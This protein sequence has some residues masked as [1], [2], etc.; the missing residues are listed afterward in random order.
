MNYLHIHGPTY[1]YRGEQLDAPTLLFVVDHHCSQWASEFEVKKLLANSKCNSK[2]HV[3]V[4]DHVVAQ[5]EFLENSCICMPYLLVKEEQ[6]FN[7]WKPTVNL[8]A[9]TS[10]FNFMINKARP[11]RD[12]LLML[13]EYF[14]LTD[15]KYTLCW[16]TAIINRSAHQAKINDKEYAD[17]T[18]VVPL[19]FKKHC[20]VTEHD[21]EHHGGLDHGTQP[22][23]YFYTQAL[24]KNIFEPTC[25]SLITEPGM[26]E[27][28]T[29]PTEKSLYAFYSGTMPLWVGG[30]GIP[31]YFKSLGF[32]I[33][34]D[35]LDH[36]YQYLEHPWDRCYYAVKNNLYWLNNFDRTHK[37]VRA[38]QSRFQHNLDLF[39]NNV[40]FNQATKII[41]S[42][43]HDIRPVLLNYLT[44][45]ATQ[46]I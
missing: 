35:I 4:F 46:D 8:S 17:I 44:Q 3:V 21:T 41:S 43:N 15:Y 29:I 9:K 26:I 30:W 1:T 12:F 38:H 27:Q 34:D 7:R 45:F 36:S 25:I 23:M 42:V 20:Y 33:F 37:F 13:I 19:N 40:F 22:N 5:K 18:G 6:Q 31:D 39:K 10:T 16:D 32:D 2:D 28:E 14:N 24:Q 11:N